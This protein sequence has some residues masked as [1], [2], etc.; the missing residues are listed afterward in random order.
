MGNENNKQS[1]NNGDETSTRNNF[2]AALLASQ[3]SAIT[4]PIDTATKRLQ[5]NSAPINNFLQFKQIILNKKP[6]AQST[7][8][9]ASIT[10]K[11][12]L[13]STAAGK[14]I[15]NS[16]WKSLY[17]GFFMSALN[18]AV[19]KTGRY[20]GQ[21]K[22]QKQLQKIVAPCTAAYLT[23]EQSNI[24]SGGMSG[25]VIGAAE[26]LVQPLDTYKTRR[27]VG[28]KITGNPFAGATA[29]ALR[30]GMAAGSFFS[31]Y[32]AVLATSK[33]K[34]NPTNRD[35]LKATS[36]ASILTTIFTNPVDV[37]KN[38]LQAMPKAEQLS[39]G[40]MFMKICHDEGVGA[41]FKGVSFKCLRLPTQ[42]MLPYVFYQFFKTYLDKNNK[43][44]NNNYEKK[45]S[46]SRPSIV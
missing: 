19:I 6:N 34:K 13:T 33:N 25:I 1:K 11:N 38:R 5:I 3:L 40:K 29:N 43:P 8:L 22:M 2:T 27:Q 42:A 44:T 14:T 41:L 4:H 26:A 10:S 32:N 36:T 12:L 20:F 24:L 21:D 31:I 7:I 35:K 18:N 28:A 39:V 23:P 16:G 9:G 15:I 45:L 30:C 37:I 17:D 46:S